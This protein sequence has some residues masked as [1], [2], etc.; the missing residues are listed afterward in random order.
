MISSLMLDS[1][2]GKHLSISID[3]RNLLDSIS[4]TKKIYKDTFLFH[5]GLQA[6]EIFIIKSGLLQVSKLTTDGKELILR[7]CNHGDMVGELSLFSDDPKYLLS[8][9]VL[10]TGEVEVIRKDELENALLSNSELTLEYMKWS[11]TQMRKF[12]SKLRDLLLNGKKGALYSTL[13]RLA[14]SYGLKHDDG[15]LIDVVLTNQELANFCAAT[16]ESINRMLVKLRQLNVISMDKSG[17]IFIKDMDYL[18]MEIG[19]ENCPLEICN[20][21]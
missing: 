17:K 2:S 4:T 16:R 9:K 18:K 13:I 5:E 3:L 21:N 7:I 1:K 12:Q 15:I 8:G 19:C 14:N 6:N 10:T 20:I 11:S